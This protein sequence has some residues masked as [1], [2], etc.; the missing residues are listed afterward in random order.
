VKGRLCKLLIL[1]VLPFVATAQESQPTDTVV[2]GPANRKAQTT[3]APLPDQQDQPA[4]RQGDLVEKRKVL[5]REGNRAVFVNN[6]DEVWSGLMEALTELQMTPKSADK[7]SGTV[8]FEAD[9]QWGSQ[10]GDANGAVARFSMKKVGGT[11][12]WL[13][14]AA[15]GNIFCK[16]VDDGTELRINFQFAGCNGWRAMGT[17]YRCVWEPLQSSGYFE[18]TLLNEIEKRLPAREWI[19]DKIPKST[20]DQKLVEAAHELLVAV[21]KIDSA[22][23]LEA[24]REVTISRMVDGLAL[25]DALDGSTRGAIMPSLVGWVR[26]A[27]ALYGKA[28]DADTN[29]DRILSEARKLVARATARLDRYETDAAPDPSPIRP[30]HIEPQTIEPN[31]SKGPQD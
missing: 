13:G 24:G 31:R 6:V 12:T 15:K 25:V 17:G 11:S 23:K 1:G 18:G 27:I 28:I 4:P 29:R 21:Q 22:I 16:R 3:E 20:V 26:D 19:Q 10:W 9:A 7:A 2:R 14:I 8:F 5:S 30:V